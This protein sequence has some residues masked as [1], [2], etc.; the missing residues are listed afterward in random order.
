MRNL[1]FYFL[2]LSCFGCSLFAKEEIKE[3]DIVIPQMESLDLQPQQ[4]SKCIISGQLIDWR[5]KPLNDSLITF[6]TAQ[7]Q[8]VVTTDESGYFEAEIT[9]SILDNLKISVQSNL[10]QA[11]LKDVL[12]LNGRESITL[13]LMFNSNN[14]IE[15]IN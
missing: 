4:V 8:F 12:P 3:K 13:D 2:L 6:A 7:G 9:Q 15:I 1:I 14:V 11:Y 5:A 10:G